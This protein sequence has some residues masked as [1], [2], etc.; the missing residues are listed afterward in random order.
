MCEFGVEM[1]GA[2]QGWQCPVCKRVY[3]PFV[4]E[5]PYCGKYDNDVRSN[6]TGTSQ[7]IIDWSR[8]MTYTGHESPE[9]T[10]NCT[11]LDSKTKMEEMEILRKMGWFQS[12]EDQD[13]EIIK[14]ILCDG[15]NTIEAGHWYG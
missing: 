4:S 15:N 9:I 6:G 3:A 10:L 12:G 14:D 7:P 11:E 1:V 8:H 13:E 5:C 2:Q